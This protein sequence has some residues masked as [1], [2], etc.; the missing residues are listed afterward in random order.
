MNG[1]FAK[2]LRSQQ[3]ITAPKCHQ[4]LQRSASINGRALN[5]QRATDRQY[6]IT[7]CVP[8][9]VRMGSSL[10]CPCILCF[11]I[12]SALNVG[13]GG[14][15]WWNIR[16]LSQQNVLREVVWY[17]LL[18]GR[19]RGVAVTFTLCQ[20]FCGIQSRKPKDACWVQTIR[21]TWYPVSR[22]VSVAFEPSF[23]GGNYPHLSV[24]P[25][26]CF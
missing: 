21:Q 4:M 18:V 19:R 3:P 6:S 23:K 11:V 17:A 5:R 10:F 12:E 1:S 14:E 15:V 13:V 24:L 2:F 25:R 7:P 26:T 22:Y 8:S 16:H 9:N 20:V